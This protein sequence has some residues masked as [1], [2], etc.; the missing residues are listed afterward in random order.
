MAFIRV[1]RI[2][3][4]PVF[5]INFVLTVFLLF[6]YKTYDQLIDLADADAVKRV[7]EFAEDHNLEMPKVFLDEAW[8]DAIFM[9]ILAIVRFF[10]KFAI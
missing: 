8:S 1:L 3:I 5:W 9:L 6:G 10:S 7:R 2:I 4:V